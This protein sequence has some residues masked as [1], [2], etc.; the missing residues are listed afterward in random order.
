MC[1]LAVPLCENVE[2]KRLHI[3]VQ[4]LVLQ[5]E[6]CHEAEVLAVNLMLL[7]VHLKEGETL[8]PVDLVPGRVA[9]GADILV[10][11]R[12]DLAHRDGHSH[13][14]PHYTTT[15]VILMEEFRMGSIL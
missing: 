15:E 7:T 4:G 8:M 6:L 14:H 2:Q 3:K 13:P 12:R 5:K 1:A 9:P 10:E 11:L